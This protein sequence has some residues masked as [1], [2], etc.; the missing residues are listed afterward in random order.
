MGLVISLAKEG[1]YYRILLSLLLI[2]LLLNL[3]IWCIDLQDKI[4]CEANHF[5]SIR[6]EFR[7]YAW[8]KA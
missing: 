3:I 1:F 7:L 8:V 2:R 5:Q 6:K 4:S